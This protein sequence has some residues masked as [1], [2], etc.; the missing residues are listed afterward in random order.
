[1]PFFVFLYLLCDILTAKRYNIHK[2]LKPMLAQNEKNFTYWN[3]IF[4]KWM[5]DEWMNES[6]CKMAWS[7][8]H[9]S[10]M[11][12]IV[13]LEGRCITQRSQHSLQNNPQDYFES[14]SLGLE[15][16]DE[17]TFLVLLLFFHKSH[18]FLWEIWNTLLT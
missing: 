10:G 2:P 7:S 3:I 15:S 12:L 1:M 16:K 5:C 11:L 17:I 4:P 18:N 6:I 13:P 9:H 14:Y 8:L